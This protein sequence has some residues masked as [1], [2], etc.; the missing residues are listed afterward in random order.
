MPIYA[1]GRK[2][3]NGSKRCAWSN[4]GGTSLDQRMADLRSLSVASPELTAGF[5]GKSREGL[6]ETLPAADGISL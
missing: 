6:N 1:L 4:E 2:S 3:A 5:F